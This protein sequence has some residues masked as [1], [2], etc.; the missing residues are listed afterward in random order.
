VLAGA[1]AIPADLKEAGKVFGLRGARVWR[2]LILPAIFP[3]LI[4]GGITAAGGAW[5]ASIVAEVVVWHHKTLAA[6]GLGALV[7]QS[8]ASGNTVAL[9]V[10]IVVMSTFVVATNRLLWRPLYRLAETRFHVEE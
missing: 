10:A 9:L 8:T 3:S 1:T 5:N 2:E 4:T 7:T 6:S